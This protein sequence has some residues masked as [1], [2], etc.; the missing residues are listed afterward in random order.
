LTDG[1]ED[2]IPAI[3]R[4]RRHDLEGERLTFQ[5]V[6]SELAGPNAAAAAGRHDE[7]IYTAAR[8]AAHA[9]LRGVSQRARQL[10]SAA[11]RLCGEIAGFWPR[12][13]PGSPSGNAPSKQCGA[14]D[15]GGE[16]RPAFERSEAGRSA[17]GYPASEHPRAGA[18]AI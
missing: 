17:P 8:A 7:A 13:T 5:E 12:A 10:A 4:F 14:A 3:R 16:E 11:S 2:D 15:R 9:R 6:V 1:P 18:P